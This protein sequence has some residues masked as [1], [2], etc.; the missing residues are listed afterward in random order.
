MSAR[1]YP[2]STRFIYSGV[3]VRGGQQKRLPKPEHPNWHF[4][5]THSAVTTL[6]AGTTFASST[7]AASACSTYFLSPGS[8]FVMPAY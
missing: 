4:S 3:G 7:P 6:P 8:V 5:R 2:V 1:V